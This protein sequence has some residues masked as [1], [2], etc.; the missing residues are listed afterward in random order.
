M[1][2]RVITLLT[3]FGTQDAY[4]GIMK[5]VILCIN[6]AARIVDLT[7]A[8]RPQD[9]RTAALVLRRAVPFFP[10]DTIHVVV[11]D[12]GVGSARRPL[13]I[14]TEHGMLLGPDN[15]VLAPAAS[16]LQRRVIRDIQN[17]HYFRHPVSHTFHGRDIFAPVAAHLARGV[18]AA[19]L[20]PAVDAMV[21]LALPTPRCTPTAVAGE[22]VLVDR[23]GNLITN[24][25]ADTLAR[26][27]AQEVS[28]SIGGSRV[29]GLVSAYAAVGEGMPLAIVGSWDVL[30][31]A[32]RNGSA[33][34]M[35]AAG[36]GTPVSVV[37]EPRQ[38]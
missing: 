20:G 36:P 11:V 5:G 3:D 25:D 32:V 9:V 2:A 28:V 22:V 37:L 33:A 17:E 19:D 16:V 27:P 38:T 34:E 23:F 29:A 31:I 14:E 15:G 1:P 24:L 10:P 12:P 21:E 7:H 8:V 18:A 26:F 30:E 4:V 6:P 35:F 13:L